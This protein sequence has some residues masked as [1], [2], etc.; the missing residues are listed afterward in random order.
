M[1]CEPVSRGAATSRT[2]ACTAAKAA[3]PAGVPDAAQQGV[4]RF[5]QGPAEGEEQQPAQDGG[6]GHPVLV[7][8]Q[9]GDGGDLDGHEQGEGHRGAHDQSQGAAKGAGQLLAVLLVAREDRDQDADESVGDDPRGQL[10]EDVGAVVEAQGLQVEQGLHHQPVEVEHEDLQQRREPDPG[11]VPEHAADLVGPEVGEAEGER[12]AAAPE[13]GPVHGDV[14]D[15]VHGVTEDERPDPAS[16]EGRGDA[17]DRGRDQGEGMGAGER[18]ELEVAPELGLGGEGRG[19]EQVEGGEDG[20]GQGRAA[21][22]HEEDGH[23]DGPRGAEDGEGR[24][25]EEVGGGEFVD[26]LVVMQQGRVQAEA[27]Q[28]PHQGEPGGGDGD[29]AEGVRR[30]LP[31]Q[32]DDGDP[33]DDPARVRAAQ[34]LGR[35]PRDP[36]DG[37]PLPGVRLPRGSPRPGLSQRRPLPARGRAAG[38]AR[39]CRARRPPV[40][41]TWGTAQETYW[42]ATHETHDGYIAAEI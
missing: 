25:Q 35:A 30:Q 32:D 40:P 19:P 6:H 11:P 12:G 20:Q 16:Q 39:C 22:V 13:H 17:R 38:S 42:I 27:A 24:I 4:D 36:A 7:Q 34:G 29:L 2:A 14:A 15:P 33:G 8:D 21:V 41:P 26:A 10:R 23:G 31:G 1:A 18:A 3:D 9:E 37:R 28:G 5:Q